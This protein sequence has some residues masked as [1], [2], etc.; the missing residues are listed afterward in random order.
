MLWY[1]LE[2]PPRGASN[3]YQ[4]H[5]FLLRSKKNISNFLTERLD[6]RIDY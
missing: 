1:S 4:Q 6:F 3:E 5:M 2:A